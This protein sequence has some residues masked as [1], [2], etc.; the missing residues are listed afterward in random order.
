MKLRKCFQVSRRRRKRNNNVGYGR[1]GKLEKEIKALV[2]ELKKSKR[3]KKGKKTK[4]TG[5]GK[6]TLAD[7]AKE[8]M[9]TNLYQKSLGG[10]GAPPIVPRP[11]VSLDTEN[12]KSEL[13][14]LKEKVKSE[15]G[16]M[17][18]EVRR[19][20][21]G[22]A[23]YQRQLTLAYQDKNEPR[24][25]MPQARSGIIGDDGEMLTMERMGEIYNALVA[26]QVRLGTKIQELEALKQMASDES[27]VNQIEAEQQQAEQKQQ[28]LEE[29]QQKFPEHDKMTFKQ[30]REYEQMAQRFLRDER[31]QH[32]GTPVAPTASTAS[33]ASSSSSSSSS[34]RI[35]TRTSLSRTTTPTSAFKVPPGAIP[36]A[37]DI[38][39][40][41]TQKSKAKGTRELAGLR[42]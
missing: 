33:T 21:T 36:R 30:M 22:M 29:V 28:Q 10:G 18:E 6:K 19:L 5:K 7:F 34:S 4:K 40:S 27:E 39:P 3:K 15:K 20:E 1:M 38:D 24:A 37:S 9:L 32:R 2:A 31:A 11:T 25:F 12:V 16:K 8:Q 14:Q 42:R 17:D 26:E 41:L 13:N 23:Q 35:P